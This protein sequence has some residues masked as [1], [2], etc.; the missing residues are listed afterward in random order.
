MNRSV[1]LLIR[2]A[3]LAGLLGANSTVQAAQGKVPEAGL[4][5][6][7]LTGAGFTAAWTDA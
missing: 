5:L 6:Q 3:A 4:S 1:N 2:A 7:A